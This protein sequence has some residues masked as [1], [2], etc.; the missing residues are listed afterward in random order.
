MACSK[1]FSGDL[2]ELTSEIIEYFRYDFSTLYS[3]ILVNR[4]FCRVAIP[5]LWE[6]PFSIT[7]ENYNFINIYL[8]NLNDDDKTK[9]NEYGIDK[10]LIPSNTLFNYPNYI[11][12]LNIQ[13][14]YYIE[15]WVKNF[16]NNYSIK[17]TF[18]SNSTILIYK[19]L[20]KIFIENGATLHTFD[21]I[22][23]VHHEYLNETFEL[24]LKNPNFIRNI[25][26]L[27]LQGITNLPKF[28]SLLSLLNSN[29]NLIST[30]H[31]QF[32]DDL[33]ISSSIIN[34]QKNLK[35]ILYKYN[36]FPSN[37]SLLSL[38]DSNCSNTLKTIIFHETDFKDINI[39]KEVFEQ[40]NC[41]ESIHILYCRSL[42]SHFIQQIV[43]ITKPFKL[44]SLFLNEPI[45]SLQLLIQKSN[46]Y[47]ENIGFRTFIIND[48]NNRQ[49]VE[50]IL[51]NCRK[52]NFFDFS[53]IHTLDHIYQTFDLIKNVG[54]NLNYISIEFDFTHTNTIKLSSIILKKLGQ[55]L[56]LKLEY[57]KLSLV[58]Y[59][60]DFKTFLDNSQNIFIK[61]L[62]IKNII[63]QSNLFEKIKKFVIKNTNQ[64][65]LPYIE[66]Y[67]IKKRRVKYLAFKEDYMGLRDLFLLKD[68]VKKFELYD[69]KVQ[70]YDDLNIYLYKYIEETY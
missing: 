31:F 26:N 56:P 66:E 7:T 4:L 14:N 11:K 37:Y 40:L 38:K 10:N 49:L 69:I 68:Q 24:I 51:S 35:K 41:L 55:I 21:V 19:S 9:L 22:S 65:I 2:P 46:N 61:K 52:I 25:K 59:T 29:C 42:N 44:R 58:I 50:K 20:F 57:L 15:L 16:N 17:Y 48:Q 47:L 28:N 67:I 30:L 5:S 62:V 64:D 18:P 43:N 53:Y 1:I 34:S 63:L 54:Q 60:T 23:Y 8:S 6:D 45:E 32:N 33:L 36:D 27:K 39:L 3:C 13:I 12:S 70:K